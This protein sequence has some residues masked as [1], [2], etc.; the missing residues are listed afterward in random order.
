MTKLVPLILGLLGLAG[1]VGAGLAMRPAADPDAMKAVG[2]TPGAHNA[3]TTEVQDQTA[4][5]YVKL[6]NQFIVPVIAEHRVSALVALSISIETPAGQ[7]EMIYGIEPRLRD[8]FLQVLFDHANTG[9]FDGAFTDSNNMAILRRS[10]LEVA[11]SQSD[12][13]ISDVLITDIARQDN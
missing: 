7:S 12:G 1:G 4:K 8:S 9:G 2:K 11:R 13:L 10:L 3:G 6:N 5:N